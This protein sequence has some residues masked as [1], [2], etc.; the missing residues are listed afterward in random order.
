MY[1]FDLASGASDTIEA[2]EGKV[3][4][5]STFEITVSGGGTA[6]IEY[7]VRGHNDYVSAGEFTST[8]EI[9]LRTQ[10]NGFRVTAADGSVTV[11]ISSRRG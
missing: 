7:R 1:I 5:N 4:E 3:F 8:G 2:P 11:T 9:L 10:V 6:T